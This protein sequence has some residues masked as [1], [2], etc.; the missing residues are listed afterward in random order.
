MMKKLLPLF[1]LALGFGASVVGA[2][3]PSTPTNFAGTWL[4][5][6]NK[7]KD[8]PK[9]LQSYRLL[10]TQ[11]AEH[12]KVQSKLEGDLRRAESRDDNYPGRRGSGRPGG[13][14]GG[15]PVG[16]PGGRRGG[17]GLPGG[18]GSVGWPG[19]GVGGPM[20]GG[21]PGTGMP[22]G[23]GRPRGGGKSRAAIAALA[24]YP[25]STEFRLD[26][27]ESSTQLG[28][29]DHADATAKAE[30]TKKGQVLK[31]SVVENGDS[32]EQVKL[33]DEWKLSK[34]GELLT[35][36]RSVHTSRGSR[37][38]HLVFFK[39]TSNPTTHEPAQ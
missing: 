4:L 14:P 32:R 29:P 23:G 22:R 8:L 38:L 17:L 9:G 31:L 24:F 33:K 20:G 13:Y 18:I 35:V 21:V 25:H 16:Y 2:R 26:G 34:D 10:V 7:S 3:T 5:D 1:C 37:T 36:E 15:S 30:W 12:L 28:G 6:V 19:G 27:G 11:D 39:D